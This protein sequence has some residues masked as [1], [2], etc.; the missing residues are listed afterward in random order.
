MHSVFARFT[1]TAVAFTTMV[2]AQSALNTTPVVSPAPRALPPIDAHERERWLLHENLDPAVLLQNVAVGG[3]YTL[4]NSPKEYGP[5]WEGFG[6]RVGMVTAEYGVKTVMEAGLGSLWGE[7]PR[8]ER[9]HGQSLATRLGHVIEMTFLARNREGN[10]MP[11]YARYLAIPG[12]SFLSNTWRPDSEA[13]AG[14]AA[15][16]TGLGF[17]TRMGENAYKEFRPRHR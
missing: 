5:H 4:T 7:D 10:T 14:D 6:K 3:I 15:V 12:S 17:L 2:S 1:M 16:R 11:A 8:Y 13:S 9:T